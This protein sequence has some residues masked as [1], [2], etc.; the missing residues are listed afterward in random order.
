[1]LARSSILRSGPGAGAVVGCTASFFGSDN[2]FAGVEVASEGGASLG[3]DV[4]GG[5]DVS[6]VGKTGVGATTGGTTG[7]EFLGEISVGS[8][9]LAGNDSGAPPRPDSDHH[10]KSIAPSNPTATAIHLPVLD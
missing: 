1:M 5:A 9:V 2:A 8:C 10:A 4:F 7:G 3:R 6:F